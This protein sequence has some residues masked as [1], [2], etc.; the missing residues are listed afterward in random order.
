MQALQKVI[1]NLTCFNNLE[2]SHKISIP[3]HYFKK[4]NITNNQLF[5]KNVKYIKAL[6]LK[7]CGPKNNFL[8]KFKFPVYHLIVGARINPNVTTTL[9]SKKGKLLLIV[10]VSVIGAIIRNLTI[11][12][13]LKIYIFFSTYFLLILL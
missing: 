2:K 4:V 5:T 12:A 6:Q 8:K 9:L 3:I 1:K 11:G 10:V 13:A 7:F